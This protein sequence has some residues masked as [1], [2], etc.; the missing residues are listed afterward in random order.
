[1]DLTL[2]H[3]KESL[4]LTAVEIINELGIQGLSTREIAKRQ[5]VSEGTI[6]RH[7]KSKSELMIG[8]LDHYSQYDSDIMI[9][10]RQKKENPLEAIIYFVNAYAEYYKNYPEIISISQNYDV[11]A[12]DPELQEK[13]KIIYN[14]RTTFMEELIE[15]VKKQ[16]KFSTY[17]ESEKL[18]NVILG[19]FSSICMKW[20]FNNQNFDLKEYS[21]STIKMILDA[22]I[23]R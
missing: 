8:V 6:F 10:A 1:M 4:I 19:S 17:V 23:I 13:I 16:G 20:R 5:G 22:F 21:I 12:R 18:T 11:F 7:Y 15:E 9:T 14:N 2:I 3:R